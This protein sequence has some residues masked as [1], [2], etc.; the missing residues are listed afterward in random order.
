MAGRASTTDGGRVAGAAS[1][2]VIDAAGV[3]DGEAPAGRAVVGF[4]LE[5]TGSDAFTTDDFGFGSATGAVSAT[6]AASVIV[7]T[8]VPGLR[9]AGAGGA[10]LIGSGSAVA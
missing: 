3:R 4:F 6:G 5:A 9:V 7:A 1:G 8:S 2:D 10:M